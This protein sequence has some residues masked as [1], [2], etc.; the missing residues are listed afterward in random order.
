VLLG[1]SALR[2]D[3]VVLEAVRDNTLYEDAA[4]A[5]SNG[6]GTYFFAGDTNQADPVNTRRGLL[7]FEVAAAV[8][9]GATVTSAA[10][11]LYMSR[12]QDGGA[13]T[14]SLHRALAD[15]GEGTSNADSN[16]GQGAPATPGDATWLHTFFDTAFWTAAGG[17]F[18]AAPSA[19]LLVGT[20][21]QAYTWSSAGLAADVQAW[22]D[23][24][25]TAYGW[26]VRGDETVLQSSRRFSTRHDSSGGGAR[27][28][29]LTVVFTPPA[30]TGACCFANGT[31]QILEPLACTGAG[32]VFQGL[33]SSCD[34]NP[35]PQP[36]GACC[37][38]DGTCMQATAAA[39]D[40]AG[41]VYHGD[42]T[43]CGTVFCPVVT[44][45]CCV[46]GSPGSC[47]DVTATQCTALGGSSR[48]DGS[49]CGIDLCPFV[50]PLPRPAIAQPVIGVPGGAASYEMS[51]TEGNQQLHRDLPPTRV[52]T[53]G[54]SFPGPT[55]EARSGL[56]VTVTW[57]NDL[58]DENG[59]LRTEH[60]LPVDLCLHG[61]DTEG[62]T[63]RT[64]THLHGGHTPAAS[65]GYPEDTR[66]P[67]EQQTFVYPNQQLASTIWYHDH[68][69]G[70]T[71]LNVYLGLAGFY[72]VRDGV[73]DALGLPTGEYEIALAIQ[74][75]AFA[76]D[77]AFAYPADWMEHFFGD[78]ILVNGKVWPYLEVDR[79]KYR[80]RLLGGSNARTVR[81][82]LSNGATFHQI[83]A[84][85]G[86]LEAPVPIQQLVLTP[87]ERAD[88]VIDFGVYPAGTILRL[89]NDAPAPFPGTPGVGV[90]P[91]V[92]EF[93]VGAAAG[94][95]DPL[96]ATLRPLEVLP[97]AS[98]VRT[99]DF[100]LRKVDEPCAGSQWLINGMGW[101]DVTERPVLGDTEIWR[102]LNYSGSVHP[103]HMHLVMFQVLDRQPFLVVDD[104]A[105][106]SGPRVP[107]LPGE[108]GW[109]DTVATYPFEI[110]R[111]IARFE[112]YAGL[113]P[114]HCHILEH[115]DHEMM[116]QFETLTR[117]IFED[118]FETGDSCQ[119]SAT[120][121]GGSCP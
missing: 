39:C 47:Q 93:R 80:L 94:D 119:W 95:V 17:D 67:G 6:L 84:E 63:A 14:V 98:A 12:T 99:R 1:A 75:R 82:A 31:C 118:G 11:T 41:G 121:G 81:L 9:A 42:G 83:G 10:L 35:C 13:R 5:Y 52:W 2:G 24:P 91:E 51:I 46:P 103:M 74:D 53:Y 32:G 105:V 87:G 86:L 3:T 59:N 77:G 88:V 117:E 54:G 96:P 112:D 37:L 25:A 65:D 79:G 56:P 21:N 38:P 61:P 34:P 7:R 64:V 30:G 55:I 120:I 44:V 45:A 49:V 115:E 60:L 106:P 40:G 57:I 29:R 27:R 100:E 76:A 69:L 43:L 97:E 78:R 114:Y 18:T 15:W 109:K 108:V 4:G 110:T 102:F 92:M 71:R 23:Q 50:D 19:T 70:I 66:L 90:V 8:P 48:G 113:Y 104:V 68:A 111:V 58:R 89:V 85:G 16:E 36:T 101:H 33:G 22:L 62:A 72:L 28:P 107:P 73:E 26:V 116:R 20:A